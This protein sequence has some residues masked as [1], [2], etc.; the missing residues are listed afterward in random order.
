MSLS[1]FSREVVTFAVGESLCECSV[2]GAKRGEGKELKYGAGTEI[3]SWTTLLLTKEVR[4]VTRESRMPMKGSIQW[5]GGGVLI[6]QI[7][8][9]GICMP[10]YST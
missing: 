2:L 7:H 1:K 6:N 4:K 9:T 3:L 8:I 5:G 10:V